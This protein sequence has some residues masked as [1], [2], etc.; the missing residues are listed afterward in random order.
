[1]TT[2]HSTTRYNQQHGRQ[3]K[4]LE[5]MP[6]DTINS[7]NLRVR[8]KHLESHTHTHTYLHDSPI[9]QQQNGRVT[10]SLTLC[11]RPKSF[12]LFF[13]T[14]IWRGRDE[15]ISLTT[16]SELSVL[17]DKSFQV[18]SNVERVSSVTACRLLT[19]KKLAVPHSRTRAHYTTSPQGL[20]R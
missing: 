8:L 12:P 6:K 2:T 13:C 10:H 15:V 3:S 5:T 20:G 14:N 17:V 9:V 4:F 1:M 19:Q 11:R 7:I 16:R 18:E